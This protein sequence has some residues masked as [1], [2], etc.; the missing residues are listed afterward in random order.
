MSMN[1]AYL[2]LTAAGTL[3]MAAFQQPA[4]QQPSQQPPAQQQPGQQQPNQQQ[5][6][7]Q[8]NQTLPTN[9]QNSQ[10]RGQQPGNQVSGAIKSNAERNARPFSFSNPE[11]EVRFMQNARQ[12]DA[13]ER[14][15]AESNL[16]LTRRLGR[17]RSMAPEAQ[18]SALFDLVQQ[19]L[20]DR[21]ALNTYLTQARTAWTGDLSDDTQTQDGS[22]NPNSTTNQNP[23]NS[24]QPTPANSQP[25]R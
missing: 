9:P 16:E 25:R 13:A 17:I 14:R 4:Q 8:P 22:T 20:Q 11:N 23:T 5:P 2:A 19:I 7:S 3:A 21:A 6:S 24:G 1:T 15:M 12:L 18:T 10:P